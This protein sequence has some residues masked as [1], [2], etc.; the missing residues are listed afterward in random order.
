MTETP[1]APKREIFGWAMF[2]FAN[3]GYTLLII[4]VI[5]GDLFTRVIVGDA[6]DYRLGNLLWS[7]ALAV[8]YLLVVVANPLCGAIM[9]YTG[10]RKRFLFASYLLTVITTA[11]LYVIEPG[12]LTLAVLLIILSNF[13]YS[14][15]EGFIASFLPDLGPRKALGW[16]S[17]LGWGLGYIGGLV[18]AIFALLF[19]GEVSADNYDTVRW[20][21]PFAAA[22]FLVAA[23]PTFT[24]LQE[25]GKPHPAPTGENLLRIGVRR[26]LTTWREVQYFR[27]LRYLLISVFFA[28]AGVYIIIAFSFIY[29]AQVIGWDEDVR[30]YM[31]IIV[32]VTAALGAVGFGW[33]QSHIGAR[34][35][36]LITLALWL[37]AI[38]AIWQTPTL[39]V[40]IANWFGVSW[41]A[42]YVFLIAGVLAGASLGSSQSATR[43]LVGVLTPKGKAAEFFGLWG[44]ASKLAAVFG[45]FG[46]GI[47]QW[48]FGLADAIVFCLL[49]FVL[50][51]L[52]VLPMREARGALAAEQWQDEAA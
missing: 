44:M 21:G 45:I 27:D 51:I 13:A 22:F 25:R 28:M 32:Q 15:G 6:P 10:S 14:I 8:S 39:T 46:L 11:L 4:T 30:V 42:Q 18:A 36:Y 38:M 26:V 37:V 3:Q 48:G 5:Y 29:G 1:M 20:V 9:D 12:W 2:D 49:L 19:L 7:L 33:L 16:I 24:W 23:I 41:E 40:L 43:A 35:T 52:C 47:I 17:G 50:A 34:T 31:F